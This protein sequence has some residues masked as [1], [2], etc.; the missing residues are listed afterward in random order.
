MRKYQDESKPPYNALFW[1]HIRHAFFR[2][3]EF[4]NFEAE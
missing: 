3:N 4:I 1:C 2:W